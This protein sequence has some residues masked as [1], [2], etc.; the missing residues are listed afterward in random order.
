V[1]KE[2]ND[3]DRLVGVRTLGYSLDHTTLYPLAF[4][5]APYSKANAGREDTLYAGYFR[6]RSRAIRGS[7]QQNGARPVPRE[8]GE[9][10]NAIDFQ[11][12]AEKEIEIAF[13]SAP[14][15]ALEAATLIGSFDHP[16]LL[17]CDPHPEHL[18]IVA[19]P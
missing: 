12:Q 13:F 17:G 5:V 1:A 7:W 11:T 18:D 6:G 14:L 2:D 16:D 19:T 10:L 9:E 15:Q 4:S 8:Q 3:A